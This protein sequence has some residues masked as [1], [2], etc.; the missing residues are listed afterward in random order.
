MHLGAIGLYQRGFKMY[1]KI[2]FVLFF[3]DGN[4]ILILASGC[5]EY[6]IL[7]PLFAA[8]RSLQLEERGSSWDALDLQGAILPHF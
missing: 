4:P 1:F 7:C 2:L 5:L 8:G 3:K 6:T